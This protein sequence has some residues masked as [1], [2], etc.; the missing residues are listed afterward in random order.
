M[1]LGQINLISNVLNTQFPDFFPNMVS[2]SPLQG[3]HPRGLYSNNVAVPSIS[4]QNAPGIKILPY[5]YLH[6]RNGNLNGSFDDI[7]GA[8]L[9]IMYSGDCGDGSVGAILSPINLVRI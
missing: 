3:F 7:K 1:A 9:F 5:A 6:L 2:F 4:E 8:N